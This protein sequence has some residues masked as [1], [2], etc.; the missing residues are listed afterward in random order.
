MIVPIPAGNALRVFVQPPAGALAWVILRKPAD[1]FTGHSDP[2][3]YV[4][5]SGT[6]LSALDDGPGLLN[7][8]PSYYR[9][10]YWTGSAW[11][12]SAT[13]AGTP[14][15]TY[16]DATEDALSVVRDRLQAGMDVEVTRGALVHPDGA[17][18][19]LD[20]PPVFDDVRFPLLTVHLQDESPQ[21]RFIGEDPTSDD[22]DK[23]L[24]AGTWSEAEGYLANVQIMVMAW[25]LNPDVRREVRKAMRRI[26]VA[27]LPVFDDHGLLN[28]SFSMQ[29]TEDFS[30]YSAPVYQTMCTI[31]CLTHIRVDSP[32][33]GLIRDVT[34]TITVN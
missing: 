2:G 11:V 32:G 6:D 3:A 30:S 29:D 24:A 1:D 18:P 17:V 13:A 22:A 14:A 34:Q 5:R 25:A 23:D 26:M 4:V 21:E 15:A 7:G 10:Y 12:A 27:N 9:A 19:V 31:R 8:T 33:A 16:S 28:M 20:A